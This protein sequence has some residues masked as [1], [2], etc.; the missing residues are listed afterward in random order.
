MR[1]KFL[2]ILILMFFST[3]AF[4]APAFSAKEDTAQLTFSKTAF[5]EK[6]VLYYTVQ[7][8][9][10][11]SAI[12]RKIPGVTEKD[13][14]Y[15][16]RMIKDINPHI[17]DLDKLRVGQKIV[18]PGKAVAVRKEKTASADAP[19][20][21]PPQKSVTP[22]AYRVKKGDH[23]IR[24][25]HRELHI[26]AN[27]QN[28]ML[29]IKSLNPSLRNANKIYAGQIIRLPG[30]QSVVK[31]GEQSVKDAAAVSLPEEQQVSSEKTTAGKD[32]IVLSP[33]ARLAVIKHIFTQM[34]ANMITS[35]NY[36]L[37]VSKTGQLTI[38]CS[39]I[40]VVEFDD[41]TTIFL[42]LENRSSHHLK[43]IISDHWSNY[44]LVKIDAKDDIITLLKKIFKNT[45]SYEISKAQKPVSL[46]S[47]PSLEILMDWL[48]TKKNKQSPS[49][50]QGLR[51]VYENNALLPRAVVNHA[52]RHSFIIT[53]I[54]PDKGLVVKPE[55]IYSLTPITVLP[56]SS[57]GDFAAA[58]LSYLKIPVE[59][60]VNLRVFNIARDGFNLS[61]K[62]D[63]KVTQGERKTII[64]SRNLPPQFVTILQKAGNEIIFI[65]DQNGPA[66]NMEKILRGLNF[67]FAS[68]YFTFS[69]LNKNQP[70]YTFGF[71]GTKIKTDKDIY[72]VNFDFNQELR[73][74]MQETWSADVIRY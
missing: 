24:I 39:M 68:G 22:Q 36:Y 26:T 27:T 58:L 12:V 48:I 13:I 49:M 5:P 35:G 44:H 60:D 45:K 23:L 63:M 9:D 46:E 32:S 8:E 47:L 17:K 28:T 1:K 55:E 71:S 31:G 10:V 53:E 25:V 38:D 66:Q 2:S 33:A 64:F 51:F 65:S 40:P 57:A 54:S 37:P 29:H 11:L 72:I 50:I 34:N 56:S 21:Q 14:P 74:L 3:M 19:V 16:Y 62:A 70:P 15:Y 7:K 18:L 20:N 43:K 6:D 52:K 59:K 61:I 4:H 41:R 67:A 42:D 69:G 30:G 73:G